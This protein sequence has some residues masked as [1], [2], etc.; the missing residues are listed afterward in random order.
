[1]DALVRA[2]VAERDVHLNVASGAKASRPELDLVLQLLRDGDT[3]VITRLD[4]SAGP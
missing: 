2:G 4:T 3:L 1:V